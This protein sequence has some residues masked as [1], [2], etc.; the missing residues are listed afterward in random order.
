ME[1]LKTPC[2]SRGFLLELMAGLEP[3]RYIQ[4]GVDVQRKTKRRFA[5]RFV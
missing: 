2:I 1:K 3:V 4:K 5:F